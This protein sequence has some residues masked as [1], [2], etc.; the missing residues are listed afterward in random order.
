[1]YNR[2]FLILEEWFSDF[3]YVGQVNI[4]A[5]D[6]LGKSSSLGKVSDWIIHAQ[7][8]IPKQND[9]LPMTFNSCSP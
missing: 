9:L 1:M 2:T 5:N 4:E 3:G 8:N 6:I 7:T